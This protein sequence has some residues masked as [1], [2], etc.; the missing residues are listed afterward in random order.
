MVLGVLSSGQCWRVAMAMQSLMT[1][2][3]VAAGKLGAVISAY[4]YQ[5]L[6][7]TCNTQR[8]MQEPTQQA[9]QHST[10]NARASCRRR[11]HDAQAAAGAHS[12]GFADG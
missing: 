4:T 2:L 11:P 8:N 7:A 10:N 3:I 1:A 5:R 12:L 6:Q 9:M